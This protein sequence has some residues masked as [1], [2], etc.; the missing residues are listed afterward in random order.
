MWLIKQDDEWH[1]L[2]LTGYSRDE[3][4]N[5]TLYTSKAKPRHGYIEM[6][7][8]LWELQGMARAQQD[9]S[10]NPDPS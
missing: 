5:V 7:D 3:Y 1:D 4:G 10:S 8:R 9:T 6:G 2:D